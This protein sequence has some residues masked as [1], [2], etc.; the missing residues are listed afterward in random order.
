MRLLTLLITCLLALSGPDDAD[1]LV[2]LGRAEVYAEK[3]SDFYKSMCTYMR[4]KYD[5]GETDIGKKDWEETIKPYEKKARMFMKMAQ[6]ELQSIKI[7]PEAVD[8]EDMEMLEDMILSA[9]N[10]GLKK[11]EEV[12]EK[13]MAKITGGMKLPGM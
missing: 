4:G 1:I 6:K 3:A 12:S 2:A 9:V 13:E 5:K 7:N 10:D 8:V 11:V